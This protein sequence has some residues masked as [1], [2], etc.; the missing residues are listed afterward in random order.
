MQL[1][2]IQKRRVFPFEAGTNKH[3]KTFV[4]L[5]TLLLAILMLAMTVV[6]CDDDGD[7]SVE[8]SEQVE[9]KYGRVGDDLPALNY[10]NDTVKFLHW[11]AFNNEYDIEQ[12]S[13][14]NVDNAIYERN[15]EIERRLNIEMTFQEE[16]GQVEYMHHFTSI[17]RQNF[18]SKTY[19]WDIISAYSRTEGMLAIQG[20]LEDLKSIEGSYIDINDK[21]WWPDNIISTV[22][23]ADK[24]YFISGDMSPNTLYL[25]HV[26]YFNK[27]MMDTYWD[28][29]ARNEGF[30]PDVDEDTGEVVASPASQWLY[31]KAYDGTWSL[32]DLIFASRG[33][34][35]KGIWVDATGNGTE[36]LDDT[37][38]FAS[39]GYLIDS[40]YTGSNLR[41]IEHT[42]DASVLKISDDYGSFKT[43]S[44][45]R[46]LGSWFAEKCAYADNGEIKDGGVK[47]DIWKPGHSLFI[48]TRVSEA[49]ITSLQFN[50]GILPCPK[51]DDNQLNYYTC[52]GNPFSLYGIYRG[53]P[54]R[55]DNKTE[56]LLELT[57]VLECWAS[58]SYRLVTPQV[59]EVNMQLKYAESQY[60]TDMFEIIR[61]SVVFD[62]GRIFANDM[63]FMSELP[64]KAAV[65]NASWATTYGAYKTSLESKLKI[66]VS[67]LV[68]VA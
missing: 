38:G 23:I 58:E 41:L 29:Y 48:A 36:G 18:E 10:K 53:L 62:L 16:L 9:D 26:I 46:K 54:V 55:N 28:S 2:K 32:D 47:S 14:D 21:P 66:I 52:M 61:S 20:Y 67:K 15:S 3:M 30:A 13:D 27:E 5:L 11:R 37:Y 7:G 22:S 65:N 1:P 57:A 45:V 35:Q 8:G 31:K 4:R 63:A 51:Y 19:A 34:D 59:F 56:T 39:Q 6:A 42:N 43:V 25:M 68:P 49:H 17:V 33:A 12:L 50:V 40:L 24:M 64:S 60:E 44:L